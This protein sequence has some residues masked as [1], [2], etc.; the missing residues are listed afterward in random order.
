MEDIVKILHD[1]F[2]IK[3]YTIIDLKEAGVLQKKYLSN[4]DIKN[5][6]FQTNL[7][8]NKNKYDFCISNY[9]FSECNKDVQI[10]Y[11][12]DIILNS[13]HG[14]M[15]NNRK[16]DYS[17]EDLL[18]LIPNSK[19]LPEIPLTGGNNYVIYW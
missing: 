15:I 2:K 12:N 14:Y 3:S 5:I 8:Y 7:D 19:L 11:L 13:T 1:V 4:F 9:A 10:A 18:E 16:D 17:K 6:E